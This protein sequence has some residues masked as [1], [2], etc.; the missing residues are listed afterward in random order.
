MTLLEVENLS[1]TRPTGGTVVSEVSLTVDARQV[2]GV[3][4][5]S[6]SGK[7][8][9]GMSLIGLVPEP[10][11]VS[12]SARLNGRELLDQTPRQWQHT[13]GREVAMVLQDPSS[14]LHPMLKIGE[15]LADHV[16]IHLG[17]D[18]AGA[19]RR[20]ITLLE[21][22]HLPDPQGLLK[23]YPHQLSGGMKQRVSIAMALACD[24]ALL[25]ADEVTTALDANIRVEIL[26]L[27]DELREATGMGIVFITHDLAM[28][29]SFAHRV[30]VFRDGSIVEAADA[31]TI[32]HDPQ[33]PYTREL[34][35]AVPHV[36]WKMGAA[37]GAEDG[38]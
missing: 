3:V 30:N 27:L 18:R 13:R 8:M 35:D 1:V 37:T 34:L 23:R 5:E 38:R 16:R 2:V 9:T 11:R 24:P 17:L 32:F 28:L 10:L 4:G 22:V 21:Q 33:H 31:A 14:S 29:S 20:A 6:G 7:T 19:K 26:R 15:Q 36:P 25:I 12:G